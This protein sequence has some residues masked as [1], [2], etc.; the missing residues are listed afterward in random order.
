MKKDIPIKIVNVYL[1]LDKCTSLSLRESFNVLNK[2]LPVLCFVPVCHY[3]H[4]HIYQDK[5]L[6]S[7]PIGRFVSFKI[8]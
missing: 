3:S 8:G 6:N 2:F 4:I 1:I 7:A 5:V